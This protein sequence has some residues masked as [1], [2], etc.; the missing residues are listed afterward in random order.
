MAKV[1]EADLA[2]AFLKAIG[3]PDTPLMRKAVVAWMRHES[4]S[5][6]IGNNPFNLRPGAAAASGVKTC[7]SRHSTS[8]GDFA[9]FCSPTD[10][11]AAAAG[12]LKSGGDDWRGYG[13]VVRAAQKGDP[14][15]FL[16]ALARSAWSGSRYGGPKNNG[17]LK[18]YAGISGIGYATLQA[19]ANVLPGVNPGGTETGGTATP[20]PP[21]ITEG[22]QREPQTDFFAAAAGFI[23]AL[24]DP[25]KWLLFLALIAGAGMTAF[26]GINIARAAA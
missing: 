23:G 9:V 6:I 21:N 2:S 25:Y 8:S 26:G 13:R 7:G 24:M 19:A 11:A 22:G 15:A 4:G 5:T 14:I 20:K 3:A 18:T 12:L 17:L 16:D 1:A 10:G